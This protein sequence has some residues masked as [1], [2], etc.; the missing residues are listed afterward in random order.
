MKDRLNSN[1]NI[2]NFLAKKIDKKKAKKVGS[3]LRYFFGVIFIIGFFISFG[4]GFKFYYIFCLLTGITLLPCLYSYLNK[5]FKIKNKKILIIIQIVI[6]LLFCCLFAL[7]IPS[8][9]KITESIGECS[10]NEKFKV[11]NGS[12]YY[13][14]LDKVEIKQDDDTYLELK[15][16]Y[17]QNNKLI[18]YFKTKI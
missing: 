5:I 7:F 18:L 10:Y 12:V 3:C 9:V 2:E 14:C 16:V 1:K 13:Y 11:K 15:K 4:I 17:V 8:E 6:P